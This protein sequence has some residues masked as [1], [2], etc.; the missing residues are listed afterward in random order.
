[1]GQTSREDGAAKASLSNKK[2][3]AEN[4]RD[5]K[6]RQLTEA[7]ITAGPGGFPWV[8]RRGF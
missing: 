7:A 1:M 8:L 5:S 2:G 6:A 4:A 3:D